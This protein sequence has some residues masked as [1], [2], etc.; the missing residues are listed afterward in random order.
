MASIDSPT[1]PA[2]PMPAS[3]QSKP[4]GAATRTICTARRDDDLAV[5]RGG[6]RSSRAEAAAGVTAPS[7]SASASA[8]LMWGWLRPI[9]A[10]SWV[11]DHR[12]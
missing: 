4:P 9:T 10:S 7:A 5:V 3:L 8:V 12:V 6:L 11:A 2:A 1:A